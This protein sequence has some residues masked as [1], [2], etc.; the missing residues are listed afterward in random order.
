MSDRDEAIDRISR[1]QSG[2]PVYCEGSEYSF[3]HDYVTAAMGEPENILQEADRLTGSNGARP[4]DYGHPRGNMQLTAD[5]WTPILGVEVTP[6]QVA[7]CMIQL[8]IARELFK[9]GRD[10]LVDIAGWARVI[11]RLSERG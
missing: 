8:K 3:F 5:L 4:D 10:N 6:K 9:E 7:L 2:E 11:E 1:A